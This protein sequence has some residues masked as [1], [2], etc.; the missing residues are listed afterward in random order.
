MV[1]SRKTNQK[2]ADAETVIHQWFNLNCKKYKWKFNI[3]FR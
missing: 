3:F 1:L 2:E